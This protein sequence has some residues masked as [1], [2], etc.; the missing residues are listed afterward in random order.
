MSLVR[1]L[2]ESG[3]A[4]LAFVLTKQKVI[5]G[6]YLDRRHPNTYQKAA[7]DWTYPTCAV[8]GCN[9]RRGLQADHR[10]DWAKTHYTVIDLLDY[11]CYFHHSK[12]T[13]DGWALVP[14]TGK[15]DFV[16]PDDPRH[17][18]HS[19]RQADGAAGPSPPD[20]A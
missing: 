11:L 17:P 1:E 2:V 9:T 20:A 12:K 14:G 19:R 16:P 10:D 8:K 18:R 4:K 5:S 3:Q 13:R 7:L 15:R 6:V